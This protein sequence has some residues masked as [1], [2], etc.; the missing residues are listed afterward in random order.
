TIPQ[1]SL[2]GDNTLPTPAPK[3]FKETCKID[4]T[5]D[6]EKIHNL[7][8]GLSPYPGAWSTLHA[9]DGNEA[10]IK[11]Y[12]TLRTDRSAPSNSVSGTVIIDCGHMYVVCGCN[13]MIEITELQAPGKKRMHADEYLRGIRWNNAKF[14]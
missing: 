10:D 13:S 6:A 9:E 1:Q 5:A 3:I 7:V 12:T 8:R 14:I 4:W 2:L 11:I